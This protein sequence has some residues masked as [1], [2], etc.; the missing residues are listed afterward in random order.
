MSGRY[1]IVQMDISESDFLHFREVMAF[2]E[3]G[4]TPSRAEIYSPEFIIGVFIYTLSFR[5][6]QKKM[7]FLEFFFIFF[8]QIIFKIFGI[9]EIMEN[10]AL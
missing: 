5:N 1:V 3:K 2:G 8:L 9:L 10:Y 4:D 6:F 7:K